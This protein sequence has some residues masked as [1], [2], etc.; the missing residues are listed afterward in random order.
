MRRITD[1]N[2]GTSLFFGNSQRREYDQGRRTASHFPAF[3]VKAIKADAQILEEGATG[4]S[5][6]NNVLTLIPYYAW[7]HRGANQMNVW[8]YQNLSVLDK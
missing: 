1:G 2:S 7:N 8:F 4:V 3:S 6:T 5:V